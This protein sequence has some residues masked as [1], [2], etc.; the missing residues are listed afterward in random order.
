MIQPDHHFALW[1]VLIAVSVFGMISERKKWFGKLAGVLVTILTM[2][3]LASAGL[4]PSASD[5][6]LDVPV[7]SF[8]NNYLLP[9]SIP[10]LLFNSDLKKI[11]KQSGKLLTAYLIGSMGVVLGA[12]LSFY[13]IN[14]GE[15]GF[16][17]LGVFIAT[18]IG[19]SV[20]FMATAET[21]GFTTSKLFA[22]T[23][24][25]DNV[26]VSLFVFLLFLI[27]SLKL[28]SR[29][30][31]TYQEEDQ[32]A[33]ETEPTE[34]S[35]A[36]NMEKIAI[37]LCISALIC[38]V[39][40]AVGPWVRT[41]TGIDINFDMLIIT[42]LTVCLANIFT[43]QFKKWSHTAYEIGMFMMYLFLA[44]I[45]AATNPLDIL[46]VGPVIIVFCLITLV[47]HLLFLLLAAR[48]LKVSLKE[49]AVASAANVGGPTIAAPMAASF[50]AQKLIT[51][52]ILV[53]MLGYVIGTA[54]GVSIGL[55][56]H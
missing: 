2:A 38:A 14:L 39:G 33:I 45:G 19:G 48:F 29:Y 13:L 32:Q 17:V 31:P 42:V 16:K 12:L 9:M 55:W 5:H 49:I 56:V 44:V 43:R 8:V 46:V 6:N 37:V 47:F 54:I 36:P 34:I 23:I 35:E 3:A 20:N 28:L 25:V 4:V 26:V 27:P 18:L 30:F 15:E 24:A 10:L 52:A 51:P 22:A 41:W 1:V 21:F 50:K 53:G 40:I 11:V 7:Y